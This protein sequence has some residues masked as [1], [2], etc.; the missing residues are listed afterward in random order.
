MDLI[1]QLPGI[2]PEVLLSSNSNGQI[3][4]FTMEV[5]V[6]KKKLSFTKLVVSFFV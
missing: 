4:F 3:K 1:E 5:F 6:L 2:S